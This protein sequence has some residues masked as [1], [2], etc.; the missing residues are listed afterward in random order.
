MQSVND[1]SGYIQMRPSPE[2]T[3]LQPPA[4]QGIYL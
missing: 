2:P 1:D 3:S 4:P